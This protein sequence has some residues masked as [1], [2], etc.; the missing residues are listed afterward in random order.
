MNAFKEDRDIF[1]A[2]AKKSF[3]YFYQLKY[4]S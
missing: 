2:N 1:A 3:Q 4:T